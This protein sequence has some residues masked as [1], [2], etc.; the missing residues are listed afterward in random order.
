LSTVPR[1]YDARADISPGSPGESDPDT[2]QVG[3]TARHLAHRPPQLGLKAS[4]IEDV[5]YGLV[6]GLG[7]AI[8]YAHAEVLT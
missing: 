6:L 3:V 7:K 4:V 2:G 5:A 1:A 8:W